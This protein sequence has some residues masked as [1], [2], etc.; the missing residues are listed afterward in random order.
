MNCENFKLN[1]ADLFDEELSADIKREM[2]EHI[3]SCDDCKALYEEF[4]NAIE[5]LT[6][7]Q[8]IAPSAEFSARLDKAIATAAPKR[9]PVRRVL[10]RVAGAVASV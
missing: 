6:P 10:F 7:K 3:E 1:I 9:Q 4:S 8:E 2:L 5:A